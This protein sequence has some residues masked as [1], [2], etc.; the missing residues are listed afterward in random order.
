MVLEQ[1]EVR[2]LA[3]EMAMALESISEPVVTGNGQAWIAPPFGKMG[4]AVDLLY[5]K[6]V[7]AGWLTGASHPAGFHELLRAAGFRNREMLVEHRVE[8]VSPEGWC[9]TIDA[10]E[11]D[12]RGYIIPTLDD[13]FGLHLPLLASWEPYHD[14]EAFA[15][16]IA[17]AYRNNIEMLGC[18]KSFRLGEYLPYE[19][20][21]SAV[22]GGAE[23]N[24]EYAGFIRMLF[25]DETGDPVAE[26]IRRHLPACRRC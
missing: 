22:V 26:V 2:G 18:G 16:A 13:G 19:R 25:D 6:W 9:W 8:D 10:W 12:G 17:G 11:L 1:R 3:R 7:D 5:R 24:D 23:A 21:V 14:R 20:Y 15:E 4:L